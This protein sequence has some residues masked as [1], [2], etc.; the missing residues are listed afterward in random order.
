MCLK[1][2]Y[3][4]SPFEDSVIVELSRLF[5]AFSEYTEYFVYF[6]AMLDVSIVL[7]AYVPPIHGIDELMLLPGSQVTEL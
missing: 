2:V 6:L 5:Y 1:Y 3:F 7:S 4:T